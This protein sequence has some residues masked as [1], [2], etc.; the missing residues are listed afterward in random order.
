[1]QYTFKYT[2]KIKLLKTLIYWIVQLRGNSH[3]IG[4]VGCY[5]CMVTYM[6]LYILIIIQSLQFLLSLYCLLDI[7]KKQNKYFN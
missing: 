1:M 6:Y 5:D 7:Q 4:R 3:L 2:A